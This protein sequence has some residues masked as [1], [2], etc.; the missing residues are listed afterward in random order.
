MI[1]LR[2]TQIE[3]RIPWRCGECPQDVKAD[4]GCA[5]GAVAA[6]PLKFVFGGRI[7]KKTHTNE[8]SFPR[9]PVAI[10]RDSAPDAVAWTDYAIRMSLAAEHGAVNVNEI[11]PGELTLIHMADDIRHARDI[12]LIFEGDGGGD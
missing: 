11:P 5:P 6:E 1:A 9:C 7:K 4:M 8:V 3:S 10:L 2:Q 12:E